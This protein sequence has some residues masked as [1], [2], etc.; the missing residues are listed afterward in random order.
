MFKPIKVGEYVK[1][2]DNEGTVKNIGAFYTEMATIDNRHVNLPNGSLTN[3]AIVNYT[4][5]GTRRLDMTFSVAYESDLDQVYEVL[6]RMVKEEKALLPPPAPEVH[7]AQCAS[8]AWIFPSWCD[9]PADYCA[10]KFRMW[11]A[12]RRPGQSGHFI[13][14]PHM[15]VHLK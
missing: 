5:E 8:A 1:I 6:N 2:G 3:T 12:A 11:T 7:L 10:V 9:Q 15:D 13:P 14:Y 4:R